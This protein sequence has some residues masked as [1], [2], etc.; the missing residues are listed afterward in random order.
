MKLYVV[1]ADTYE[2]CWGSTVELLRVVDN[3]ESALISVGYAEEKG[4]VP[5]ITVVEENKPIRKYL[6]GYEE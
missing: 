3:K 6:G 5:K 2:G 1:T 4:W